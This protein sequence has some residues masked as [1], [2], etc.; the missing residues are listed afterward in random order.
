M[1]AL[2]GVAEAGEER[3]FWGQPSATAR[4]RARA[5]RRARVA[6]KAGC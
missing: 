6:A 2:R 5:S 4:G 1:S 3:W